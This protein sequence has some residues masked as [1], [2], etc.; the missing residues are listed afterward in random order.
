MQQGADGNGITSKGWVEGTGVQSSWWSQEEGNETPEQSLQAPIPPFSER[1][2]E[3]CSPT[4]TM[5]E[6]VRLVSSVV[7]Y[8][9]LRPHRSSFQ[10]STGQEAPGSR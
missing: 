3:H 8:L 2:C 6:G 9:F 1:V 10:I 7:F 4:G 5:L